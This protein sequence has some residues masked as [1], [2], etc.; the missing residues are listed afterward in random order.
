MQI[1]DFFSAGQMFLHRVFGYRGVLLF[2]WTA[3]VIDRDQQTTKD[4]E[5]FE[6]TK[7]TSKSRGA[8]NTSE[9]PTGTKPKDGKMSTTTYYQVSDLKHRYNLHEILVG[10]LA[11]LARFD[12]I[13]HANLSALPTE[14][15]SKLHFC[16][17]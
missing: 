3:R 4:G 1:F 16:Q 12:Y 2:P 6:N 17:L 15:L 5:K 10:S 11:D 8:R 7:S 13:F 14:L 9:N